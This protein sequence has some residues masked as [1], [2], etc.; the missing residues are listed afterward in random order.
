[1]LFGGLFVLTPYSAAHGQ[2]TKRDFLF[3]EPRGSLTLYG[4]FAQPGASSDLFTFTTEQLTLGKSDFAGFSYGVDLGFRVSSRGEIVLGVAGSG[5]NRKSEFRD[6]VDGDDLPIEQRTRFS[7]T[8]IGASF[9][10]YLRPSG[11]RI[12]SFAWIP[13]RF[14]PWASVGGGM[15]NYKFEQTGDFVDYETLDIFSDRFVSTGW[16]PFAQG[17]VGAGYSV[18]TRWQL[19][20]ELKYMHGRGKL[21]N[22]FEGFD[23]LDLSGLSTS[24][25]MS[26]RF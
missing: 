19:V 16:A 22:S 3:G 12:G 23:K 8:P 11:E 18:S 5:S 6:W 14:T 21:S 17:A 9:K 24:I 10:Y 13:N 4:G 15:M 2:S 25:G 20:G 7:R 26:V 1:M